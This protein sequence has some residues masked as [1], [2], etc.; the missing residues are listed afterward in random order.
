MSSPLHLPSIPSLEDIR[1]SERAAHHSSLSWDREP[2]RE[3]QKELLNPTDAPEASRKRPGP[4]VPEPMVF[5]LIRPLGSRQGE[6][7]VNVL[8]LIPLRRTT[9]RS[10]QFSFITGSDPAATRRPSFEWAPEIEYTPIDNFSIEFEL[11]FAD[12]RLEAYKG[13]AQYTFGTAFDDHFIHGVQGI[14]FVDRGTTA[15]NTTLLY[16]AAVR[17][18]EMYSLQGMFGFSNEF[19]GKNI[20]N[21][22]QILINAALFAEL[23][24]TWVV[25]VEVNYAA[26]LDGAAGLLFM[27]QLHWSPTE[28]FTLQAGVGTRALEGNFTGEA[29]FRIIRE[30]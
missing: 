2:N 12:T 10:P 17:F 29:A 25:G 4:D 27:P 16:L 14:L 13:A 11:P 28:L 23:N 26:E 19:G 7:E 8:G 18:D 6:L 24:D 3:I 22:T 15:I 1:L 21:P 20:R 30:F 9:S 5:D